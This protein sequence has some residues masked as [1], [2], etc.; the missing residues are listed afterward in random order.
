MTAGSSTVKI[1]FLQAEM[2]G[3]DE[4]GQS[5]WL[6]SPARRLENVHGDTHVD[7]ET[8]KQ[9]PLCVDVMLQCNPL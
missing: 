7:E 3:I 8:T 6:C 1:S 9:V 4:A 2:G 5:N